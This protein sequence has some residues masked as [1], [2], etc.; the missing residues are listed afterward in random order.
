M[1]GFIMAKILKK[2]FFE[3]EIPLL[4]ENYEVLGS[5]LDELSNKVIKIDAT[6]KLRGKGIDILFRIELKEGKAIAVPK[7]LKLLPSF[8]VHMMHKG[9]TYVEDSIKAETKESKVIIKPFLITRKKVSRAVRRT[10][11][12]S[13]RNWLID[14][15]K[16]KEDNEVFQ[17]ILSNQV[18]KPLSLK[19]KKIYPLAICEIRVFEVKG[20]LEKPSEKKEIKEIEQT[21]IKK[22]EKV[23]D[24]T[25]EKEAEKKEIKIEEKIEIAKPEIKEAETKEEAP[26]RKRTSKK[27]EKNK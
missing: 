11:R 18:Q 26:K 6:R 24:K 17:E 10:L 22:E 2:K 13:A 4:N 21:E 20:R 8:M 14:Y 25:A 5:S 27:L 7:K 3:V 12:N 16:T 23:E 19:L 1:G 15:L 9:I